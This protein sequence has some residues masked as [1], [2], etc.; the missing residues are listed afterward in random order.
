MYGQSAPVSLSLG[1]LGSEIID[2]TEEHTGDFG[3]IYALQSCVI[4]TL[5]TANKANG[6]PIMRGTLTSIPL[7]AGAALYGRFTSITLSS[8][9]AFAYDI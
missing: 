2:D 3:I 4:G 1:Q 8:G 7:P 6:D 5:V 9:Y